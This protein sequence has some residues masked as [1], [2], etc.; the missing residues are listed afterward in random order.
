MRVLVMSLLPVFVWATVACVVICASHAEGEFVE[1][2]AIA[3]GIGFDVPCD[4]DCCPIVSSPS[5][6]PEKLVD[7]T[8]G[9]VSDRSSRLL[10]IETCERGIKVATAGP[11]HRPPFIRLRTLRI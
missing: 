3:V 5:W 1:A 7:G 2:G 8:L 10:L 6:R 11:G 9:H 4:D